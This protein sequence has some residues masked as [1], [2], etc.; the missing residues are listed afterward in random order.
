MHARGTERLR[1]Q[2]SRQRGVDPAGEPD[3]DLAEAVLVYVRPQPELEREAHLLQIVHER[4]D[5]ARCRRCL[6]RRD[7]ELDDAGR[8]HLLEL[9]RERAPAHVA[10]SPP[11]RRRRID[12]DDEQ[13]FFESR[14]AGDHLA[15]VVEHDRVPVEDELVLAAGHV[16]ERDERRVVARAGGEHLLPLAVLADVERRRRHVHEQL[17]AGQREVGRRR[18]GLPHVLADRHADECLAEPQQHEVATGREVPVLVE[19][20][21]VG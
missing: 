2:S 9:P 14:G 17:R 7:L 8:W 11:N 20:A 4:R 13:R 3:D 16:A 10:Q 6:R 21:V 15:L 5:A 1:R 12:I 18:S 19:H